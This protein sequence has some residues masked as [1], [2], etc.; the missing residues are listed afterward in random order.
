MTFEKENQIKI[1]YEIVGRRDGDIDACYAECSL[2]QKELGWNLERKS[3][4]RIEWKYDFS[5]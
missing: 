5:K 3:E 2:A 1:P 4:Q